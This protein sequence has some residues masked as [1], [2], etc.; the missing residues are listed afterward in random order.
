MR[1]PSSPISLTTHSTS[2]AERGPASR[3][4]LAFI[5]SISRVKTL[6]GFSS[7]MRSDLI[8][9]SLPEDKATRIRPPACLMT[10]A[11][12]PA[13]ARTLPLR[14][15]S[16]KTILSPVWNWGLDSIALSFFL[17][18]KLS[19]T[20]IRL[21]ELQLNYTILN[22][23]L[24]IELPLPPFRYFFVVAGEKNFG[25][26]VFSFFMNYYFRT[27]VDFRRCLA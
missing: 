14:E 20:D 13:D 16:T 27:S 5:A 10:E 12:V 19:R 7:M 15:S 21:L 24:S 23:Y 8:L 22:E 18:V 6:G 25:D 1:T 4:I 2:S 3:R 17:R 26:C 9:I 11:T